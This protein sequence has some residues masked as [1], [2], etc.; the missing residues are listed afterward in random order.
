MPYEQPKNFD[1]KIERKTKFAGKRPISLN[2]IF[3]SSSRQL[4]RNNSVQ[5]Y[6]TRMLRSG[7]SQHS[8]SSKG[9]NFDK[10]SID[11]QSASKMPWIEEED[12]KQ[13][14]DMESTLRQRNA[15]LEGHKLP[16]HVQMNANTIQTDSGVKVSINLG[17]SNKSLK[18]SVRYRPE[19]KESLVRSRNSKLSREFNTVEMGKR[20][21]KHSLSNIQ[22]IANKEIKDYGQVKLRK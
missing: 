14:D 15:S 1:T 3:T 22:N 4:T 12:S 8:S 16:A 20:Q 18:H 9:A 2:R 7:L 13:I 5:N 19:V 10:S 11:R 21:L 17:Q 6:Q